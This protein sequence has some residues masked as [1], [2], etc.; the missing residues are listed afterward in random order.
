QVSV[1]REEQR[2]TRTNS[3]QSPNPS[4]KRIKAMASRLVAAAASSSSSAPS[5]MPRLISRRGLA[6]A[7]GGYDYDYLKVNLWEDPKRP[8]RWKR[9]HFIVATIG[10]WGVFAYGGCK[11][12][13]WVYYELD[14][15]D[16]TKG[17]AAK[18]KAK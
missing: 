5:L 6:R 15:E 9:S 2:P 3:L 16:K 11:L 12:F 1:R 8:M 4:A 10:V 18:A 13:D 7:S 14:R 17:S